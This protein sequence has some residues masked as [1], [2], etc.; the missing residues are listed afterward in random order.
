[1]RTVLLVDDDADCRL[2]AKWFLGFFGYAV[3]SARTAE[4]ALAIF[5]PKIHDIIVTDNRMSGM[6]GAEMAHIIKL[7]SPATPVLMYTGMPPTD[8]SCLDAVVQRPTHLLV[9]KDTVARLLSGQ[10]STRPA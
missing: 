9:L 10:H 4:E 6:S 7:R 8:Q 5:D 3:E 1:M 2:T